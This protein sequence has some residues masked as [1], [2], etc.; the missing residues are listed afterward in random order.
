M[1]WYRSE[2]DYGVLELSG[3]DRVGHFHCCCMDV[4]GKDGV[5]CA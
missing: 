2:A 5:G 1:W 3:K 4:R